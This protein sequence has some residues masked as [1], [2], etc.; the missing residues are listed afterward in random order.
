[1]KDK[2]A[3]LTLLVLAAWSLSAQAEPVVDSWYRPIGAKYARIYKTQTDALAGNSVST[4]IP[5]GRVV[6]GTQATPV[7]GGVLSIRVSANWVYVTGSGLPD[8]VMGPWY[9]DAAKTAQNIFPNWP[10][11]QNKLSRFPRTPPNP[12]ASKTKTSLGAI[13][14]WVDGGIIHNQL[15]A[16]YYNGTADANT[17]SVFTQSWQRNAAFAEGL[18]WDPSGS[19]QPYTGERHHHLN[20]TALRHELGD[21]VDYNPATHTYSESTSAPNHSPILGWSFDGFPIYG[22][23]GYSNPNDA[24]SGVRRMITG[25][26]PRD[27]NFGTTNLNTAGRLTYPAWAISIG[28]PNSVNGPNVSTS[29]P[30]GWYVQ[31]F[32]HIADHGY[33]Q[34]TGATVRDFDLDR[35]NGR[36]CK[37]P[38]FP[39]GTYAYFLTINAD[40]T[41]AFP[42]II[43][44]QYYGQ[45]TGGDY[46]APASVGFT[47][48][49]TPNTTI[50]LGGADATDNVTTFQKNG[51]SVTLTWSSVEGGHYDVQSSSDLANWTASQTNIS[52]NGTST[53][54][55][56][57][58]SG[59]RGFFRAVRTSVNTYDPV[60]TP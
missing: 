57:P 27:G 58:S 15:D 11:N 60:T 22:P 1:M 43:G 14:M 48:V 12:I 37:T 31:D 29:Y 21:H 24:T 40:G 33:T 19:H 10:S 13:A 16:F 5:S 46:G 49:E 54:T 30:L 53:T 17:A 35:Y 8:Y 2:L 45:R 47:G 41:P 26:V 59:A 3:P 50:F 9:L 56:I 7:Y 32:D 34:T 38:E 44:L 28:K 52:A 51:G 39:N 4:W 18:T 6:N 20:P 55:S 42:Y 25:F 36:T 23:Y